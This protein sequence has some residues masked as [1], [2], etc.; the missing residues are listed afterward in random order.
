M[1]RDGIGERAEDYV[2]LAT[3]ALRASVNSMLIVGLFDGCATGLVYAIAGVMHAAIWAAITGLL[4]LV[5]F[6]GYVAVT[7]VSLQLSTTGAATPALASFGAGCVVLF[8]GDKIV[9][10]VLAGEATHLRFVWSLMACL[11]GF[12]VLGLVGIVV[13]PVV[14]TLARELWEQRVRDL[15]SPKAADSTSPA[16]DGM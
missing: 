2:D 12:E 6:L 5:P 15:A 7:A 14:L 13:G 10:P 3:R 16:D 11:G 8:C 4:G 1:V 9:R